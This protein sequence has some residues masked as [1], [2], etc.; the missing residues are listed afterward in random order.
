M[1]IYIFIYIYRYIYIFF[2]L[3]LE[4]YTS[5]QNLLGICK[6]SSDSQQDSIYLIK[7]T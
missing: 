6:T 2:L 4:T 5:L 1:Y 3:G 7:Y